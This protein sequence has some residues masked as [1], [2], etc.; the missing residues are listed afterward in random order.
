MWEINP[1][2]KG[3]LRIV[4]NGVKMKL[5]PFHD[6]IFFEDWQEKQNVVEWLQRIC[7]ILFTNDRIFNKKQIE[8]TSWRLYNVLKDF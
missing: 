6:E 3:A 8:N 4:A 5:A 1:S 7:I 2:A